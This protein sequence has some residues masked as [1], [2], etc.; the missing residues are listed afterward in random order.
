[1]RQNALRVDLKDGREASYDPRR[2]RGVTVYETAERNFSKGDRIQL[3][4]PN[5][6]GRNCES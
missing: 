3:T 6:V 1:V 5:P 2:L 4:A